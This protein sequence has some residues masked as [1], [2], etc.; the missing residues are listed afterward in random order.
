[1]SWRVLMCPS[2]AVLA[3]LAGY[4]EG[5]VRVSNAGALAGFH[6][7]ALRLLLVRPLQLEGERGG[8][9]LLWCN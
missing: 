1:M 3:L 5:G 2:S 8:R 6:R 4:S 7:E 9:A